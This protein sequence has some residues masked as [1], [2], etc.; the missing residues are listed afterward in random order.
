MTRQSDRGVQVTSHRFAD[1]GHVNHFRLYP[2]EYGKLVLDFI[3]S[4]TNVHLSDE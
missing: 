2:A 1:A 3:E 4:I